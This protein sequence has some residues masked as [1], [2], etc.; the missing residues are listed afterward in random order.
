MPTPEA[1]GAGAP[2]VAGLAPVCACSWAR[3]APSE[4]DSTPIDAGLAC[5]AVGAGTA[6]GALL[7]WE[8]P[9][10]LCPAAEPFSPV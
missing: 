5:A 2:V 1:D 4:L 10:A 9:P 3:E 7:A 6:A 8:E